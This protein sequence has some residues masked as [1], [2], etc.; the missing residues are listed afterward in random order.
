[1]VN[2]GNRKGD[3][4]KGGKIEEDRPKGDKV[5]LGKEQGQNQ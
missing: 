4:M 2:P 3:R 5:V 1:V